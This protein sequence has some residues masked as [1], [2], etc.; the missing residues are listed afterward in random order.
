MNYYI[1]D[2]HFGHKNVIRFDGR[3]FSDEE[4]MEKVMVANWN[5]AVS[6]EDMVYILGDFCWKSA[7][8]WLRI[9]NKLRG[10]KVLIRGNHDLKDMPAE[11]AECF[12]DIR[13]YME[14]EDGSRRVI[15]C[16]YPIPFYKK[17]HGKRSHMLCG[18][19]HN[20]EENTSL[21]YLCRHLRENRELA[22]KPD[23][24]LNRGQIYNVGTMMPWMNYTPRTLNEIVEGWNKA[25]EISEEDLP[26]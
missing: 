3:P 5:N 23:S 10:S 9:L 18:H 11:L 17:S 7:K 8:E 15:M 13:D 1:A 16:H 4:E 19:V 12:V 14:I 21:E 25:H 22:E 6:D 24:P 2:T 20:T 26:E